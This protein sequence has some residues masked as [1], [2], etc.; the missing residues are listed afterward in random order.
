MLK[1]LFTAPLFAAPLLAA[2]LL[3]PLSGPQPDVARADDVVDTTTPPV[4]TVHSN[5]GTITITAGDG[6]NV[7]VLSGA[8]QRVKVSRFTPNRFDNTHIMLP[9]RFVRV[10]YGRGFRMYRL[11][12]RQFAVPMAR[13]D[14]EGV[15]VENPGG[16]M[17][18][19]V[20][21]RVGAIFINA[22]SGNV[23]IEKLR[24]PYIIS[25]TGGS[26]NMRNVAGRGL[27]RTTSGN[28]T[29]GGVGGD[30]HLQTASGA[31]TVF[32]SYADRADVVSEDG[33]ITWR[34]ASIGDGAYH[35]RSKLGAI[36]LGFRPGV[37]AQVDI[38]SDTG[39]VQNLFAGTP[40]AA[41]AV[42]RVSLPHALSIA[43]N[44]GGPEVTATTTGGDI[45]VEPLSAPSPL[46]QQ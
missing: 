6:S 18:I 22:E 23:A 20:P 28:I 32:A 31:I 35:F 14:N 40:Y 19:A 41:S 10:R 44:G 29:L 26:V 13:F 46:P 17:S 2:V 24:G 25:A 43:V 11:P 34:F 39:N 7:R 5:G 36:H 16:D 1:K 15:N 42:V 27:I 37:A 9:E 3:M 33:P 4:L 38:Q 45:T 21:K 12:A 30:V 8:A